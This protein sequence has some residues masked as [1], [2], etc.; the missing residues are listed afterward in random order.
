MQSA[1][2]FN[3]SSIFVHCT[4]QALSPNDSMLYVSDFS[5]NKVHSFV[6]ETLQWT[7]TSSSAVTQQSSAKKKKSKSATKAAQQRKSR[8][9]RSQA[10]LG[11]FNVPISVAVS[12]DSR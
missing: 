11:S 2:V 8:Q 12:H 9:D 5:H 10:P 4:L 1:Y 3:W 7:G 6:R